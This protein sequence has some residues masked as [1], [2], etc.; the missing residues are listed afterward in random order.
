V[1]N[2]VNISAYSVIKI[3]KKI[4][5]QLSQMKVRDTLNNQFRLYEYITKLNTNLLQYLENNNI[6]INYYCFFSKIIDNIH[7]VITSQTTKR[8]F[9]GYRLVTIQDV[10]KGNNI[11]EHGGNVNIIFDNVNIKVTLIIDDIEDI[12]NKL[13][14]VIKNF[15]GR[16][17]SNG[18]VDFYY[19]NDKS[20][21]ESDI[22]KII[23]FKNLNIINN[24]KNL[25]ELTFDDFYNQP[26]SENMLPNSLQS[27]TFG[28]LY[29]QP[30]S[31]N[32][33]PNSLQSLTF[34][35]SYNK[36][37]N[38]NALPNSLL[39]ICFDF[40]NSHYYYPNGTHTDRLIPLEFKN[41]VKHINTNY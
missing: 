26:I 23:N 14:I 12:S 36:I 40:T 29:N 1:V 13:G 35:Y 6:D 7:Y 19:H 3:E 4:L 41:R 32:V 21:L 22:I 37:I 30:I 10:E 9:N 34:H 11:S 15:N 31:E 25:R 18:L 5:L 16:L 27:L 38:A 17:V 20:I 33:L 39:K 2:I 24:F 8:K 28:N